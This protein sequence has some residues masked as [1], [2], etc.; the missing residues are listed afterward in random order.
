MPATWL[1]RTLADP[2]WIGI[3][4]V[5]ATS[6]AIEL[7]L[8]D[9]PPVR[10]ATV[11]LPA[12]ATAPWLRAAHPRLVASAPLSWLR[13]VASLA[14]ATVSAGHVTPVVRTE[15]DLLV[16]RWQPLP[17]AVIGEALAALGAA[18]PPIVLPDPD[19]PTTVADIYAVLVDAAA[20]HRLADHWWKPDLPS[21]RAPSV[22][23]VRARV[24]RP[25]R[26]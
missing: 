6:R 21:S 2:R 11:R 13:S 7:G 1:D 26:P 18:M 14:E 25:L 19:D 22:A 15:R 8:P 23:G 4:A 16:A 9:G 3:P 24:P 12:D 20:R 10:P 5:S 17:D